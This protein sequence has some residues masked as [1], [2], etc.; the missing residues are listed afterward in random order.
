MHV[1]RESPLLVLFLVAAAG[2]LVGQIEVAGFSLGIAAVLFAGLALGALDPELALPEIVQ[3]FGLVLF[4]YGIGVSSGPGFFASFRRRGLRDN[5]VAFGLL[6]FATALTSALAIA[7]GL[8]GATAAGAFSGALTNT[9]ALASVIESMKASAPASSAPAVAYSVT[10]P[11]GVI[12]VIVAMWIARRTS[13]AS[14]EV[15]EQG[16]PSLR[17]AP[18]S[19]ENL[20]VRVTRAFPS[21]QAAKET[22]HDAGLSILF[23][24][25]KRGATV[26]LATDGASLKP[27]DLVTLVGR[28]GDLAEAAKM[29]GEPSE[30]HIDLDRRVLDFRRIFVSNAEV[31]EK[32]LASLRLPERFGAIVTRLRRGDVELLPESATLLELGDRVRVVAPRERMGEIARFFG[33]SYK[34][35]AEIDVITFGVGVALGLLVGSIPVPLPGGSSFRL[36]LAGGPLVVGLVLGRLGRT[37]RLVWTLPYSANLTLRQLGLVLFLAGVGTRSGDAFVRT[38]RDGGLVIFALG[39]IVTCVVA[40]AM[41]VIGRRVLAIPMPLLLG[42]VAGLHTQPAVLAFAG[43]Q[44]KSD[45]PNVGY[46]AI[47][48]LATIAKIVFAQ[49][50]LILIR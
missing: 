42:M 10:Y 19:L 37:G 41:L 7:L 24:R 29:I 6:A 34:A 16:R 25:M 28:E 11:M 18:R 47:Y 12:G 44:T 5:A 30:E 49:L 21:V 43:Q 1:L 38:L 17:P 27:G 35:L 9:P 8:S 48:P 50:L 39:A 40:T 23:G 3:G 45:Q 4:V 14:E 20:T 22:L 36:G 32:P 33:D 2:Y 46:A 26:L 13:R 31:T 15:D